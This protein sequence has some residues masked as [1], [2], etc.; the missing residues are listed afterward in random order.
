MLV[1]S[2]VFVMLA[3]V[4]H[5]LACFR[6]SCQPVRCVDMVIDH[7]ATLALAQSLDV[8]YVAGCNA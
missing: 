4:P 2:D 3:R 8:G 5:K 6:E 7:E 1:W